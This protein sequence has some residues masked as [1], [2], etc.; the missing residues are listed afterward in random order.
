MNGDT[1]RGALPAALVLHPP[2]G[3][4]PPEGRW[5]RAHEAKDWGGCAT[6]GW[7]VGANHGAGLEF[8]PRENP[9]IWHRQRAR[10]TRGD[11]RLLRYSLTAN[12]F[13]ALRTPQLGCLSATAWIFPP[14][15][16]MRDVAG[17]WMTRVMSE[18]VAWTIVFTSNKVH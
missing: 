4:S 5:N 1:P 2:R 8:L 11:Q 7:V 17:P 3:Q 13:L 18:P 10:V 16:L 15:S 6:K 14:A 12:N 9:P